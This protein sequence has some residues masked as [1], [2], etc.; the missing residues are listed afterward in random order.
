MWRSWNDHKKVSRLW[1]W[2]RRVVYAAPCNNCL[3]Y[4]VVLHWHLLQNRSHG[5]MYQAVNSSF[6]SQKRFRKKNDTNPSLKPENRDRTNFCHILLST[7]FHYQQATSQK[8]TCILEYVLIRT[9]CTYNRPPI[10][11]WWKSSCFVCFFL[12]MISV[13]MSDASAK[14]RS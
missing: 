4:D 1:L 10:L 9:S 14:E 5:D 13:R 12:F 8:C 7:L 11:I 2:Q 3:R 6:S